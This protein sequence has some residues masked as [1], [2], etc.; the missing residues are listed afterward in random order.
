V[1]AC[2]HTSRVV[3]G[4]QQ[5]AAGSFPYPNDVAGCGCA[6][7][8]ILTDKQLLDTVGGTNLGN[9]LSN[10]GV[11]VAAITAND[12]DGAVDALRNGLKDAG[13]EG[14]R[15]VVLLEDLDLL[16]QAR[17][18]GQGGLALLKFWGY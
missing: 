5:D 10:L 4:R 9:Q 12:E 15:V 13:D 8:A 11:P 18:V 7:D 17:T 2:G 3:A 6:E 16:T 14:F 1:P